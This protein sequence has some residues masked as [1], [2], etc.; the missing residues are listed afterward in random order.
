[1]SN[2]VACW[3]PL[4]DLALERKML[5]NQRD[6]ACLDSQQSL[7]E[8]CPGQVTLPPGKDP[9]LQLLDLLPGKVGESSL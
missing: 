8:G 2:L 7:G 5:I 9:I 1:L 6:L 3:F 4:H